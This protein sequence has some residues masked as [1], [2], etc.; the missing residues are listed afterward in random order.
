MIT[1]IKLETRF[2]D[3]FKNVFKNVLSLP[4]EKINKI[5]LA[6]II[7]DHSIL[8]F[9]KLRLLYD[10]LKVIGEKYIIFAEYDRKIL[11]A[12]KYISSCINNEDCETDFCMK[13]EGSDICNLKIPKNNLISGKD[14]ED[15]YYLKLADEFIRLSMI[16]KL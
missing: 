5:K 1:N 11:N 15:I 9:D 2:F 10:E 12:I 7:N 16:M 13:V 4:S 6:K 8:Y 3:S 14:N